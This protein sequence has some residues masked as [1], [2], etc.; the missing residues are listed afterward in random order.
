LPHQLPRVA[1]GHL[2]V[3][4][5]ADLDQLD[6]RLFGGPDE[7]G[8]HHPQPA[9]LHGLVGVANPVAPAPRVARHETVA[10]DV[11][12]FDDP[13]VAQR[14]E[15]PE[16][17]VLAREATRKSIVLMKNQGSLLPLDLENVKS[18]A[19]I[20][21][22]ANKVISDLYAGTPPY[23]ITIL[24]G[25]KAA[26]GENATVKFA[27]SN[28][29]DSA[30]NA[31]KSCDVAIVCVGNHP[32]SYGL[33]W[34]Q[35]QVPS[36]GREDV[37][38]Q[39]ITLEQEDLVKLVHAAN[40][41]TVLVLVSSFPYS[42]NWSKEHIP[43][44][45]HVSQSS[46]ELGSAVADVV[47]GKV[48]PAGRLVQTWITSIDQL[49]PILDYNIRNGRTYMYNQYPPLFPF[50]H[51][52]TYTTFR[53]SGL[54]LSKKSVSEGETV[55]V[56]FSIQNT[57]NYDS[58]EV[59][60]LYV[61]YPTSKIVRPV[62]ELKGFSRIFIKKGETKSVTIDLKADDL[63]YWDETTGQWDLEKG[64]VKFFIGSSS[65]EERLKGTL[66]II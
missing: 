62:K 12:L 36:D 4:L 22:S 18:V 59:P 40:P 26:L 64:L 34:G 58:D 65:I 7:P 6:V 54:K 49:P 55:N 16:A 33:G 23:N 37:D 43:S 10:V 56:T 31:A 13:A 45:L 50:G 17:Q 47:F 53:Y 46:Q 25:I 32:L 57:G 66:E 52:L 19:V 2:R 24:E 61:S 14:V 8:V 48:S 38:R 29:A 21:P 15:Q 42:I 63:K 30:V 60:Q 27:E 9:V 44:I 1:H 11:D 28:K 39:A 51:G 41:N 20:G 35:N 5:I 3:V